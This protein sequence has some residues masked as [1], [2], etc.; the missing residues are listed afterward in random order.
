MPTINITFSFINN[1]SPHQQF[2]KFIIKKFVSL[3]LLLFFWVKSMNLSGHLD[4]IAIKFFF[5][6]FFYLFIA[7]IV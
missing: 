4:L 7:F 5:F 3:I 2:V 6:I 1:H